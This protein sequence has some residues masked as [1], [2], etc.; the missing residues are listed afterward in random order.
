MCRLGVVSWLLILFLGGFS[1]S[2]AE[3]HLSNG[4]VLKGEAASF[5]DD[6]LV[7]RL[8]IGGFSPRIPWGKFTQETLKELSTNPQAKEFVEPYID[9]P[10]EVKEKE[11]KKKKE[12]R[13]AEPPRVPL[14]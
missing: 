8:D 5:N 4:D 11:K 9:I 3:Y 10:I 6:G 1:A 2:G 12:I 7:V 14:V 13:V